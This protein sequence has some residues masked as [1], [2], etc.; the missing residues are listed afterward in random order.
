MANRRAEPETPSPT[1]VEDVIR[2][3]VRRHWAQNDA[4]ASFPKSDNIRCTTGKKDISCWTDVLTGKHYSGPYHLKIKMILDKIGPD[5]NFVM[6]YRELILDA[7]TI[8]AANE[9]DDVNN[10]HT[11]IQ[12]GWAPMIHRLPCQL[13]R[14]DRIVCSPVGESA[15]VLS[16]KRMQ[17]RAGE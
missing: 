3:I 9:A 4:N 13:H 17:A 5:G 15:F 12:P 7:S 10:L 2:D 6:T 16:G 8:P 1:R 11:A 14:P